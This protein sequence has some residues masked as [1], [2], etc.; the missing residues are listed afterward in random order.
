MNNFDFYNPTPIAFGKDR[1]GDLS[2][3]LTPAVSR[4]V[5]TAAL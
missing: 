1:V 2:R 4:R 3:L 5:L